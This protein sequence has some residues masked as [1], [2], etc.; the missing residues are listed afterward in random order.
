[1]HAD[2]HQHLAVAGRQVT[3]G[4][5]ECGDLDHRVL[6]GRR[7]EHPLQL[8]VVLRL[9]E[10]VAPPSDQAAEAV[11][12][13]REQP[14]LEV[15]ARRELPLRPQ[16]VHDRVLHEIVGE[17]PIA[18][19]EAARERPQAGHRRHDVLL[20]DRHRAAPPMLL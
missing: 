9:L 3:E 10:A 20:K 17:L 15:G 6:G 19:R 16:G 5:P 8:L 14:R 2:Q 4:A 12:Q 18:V 1:M 13:D 11:A 7:P